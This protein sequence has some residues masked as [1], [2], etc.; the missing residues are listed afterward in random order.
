MCLVLFWLVG[1]V[2][3]LAQSFLVVWWLVWCFAGV[4]VRGLVVVCWCL[5]CVGSV[6]DWCCRVWIEGY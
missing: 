6:V 5:I 3:C 2:W 1:G 4:F